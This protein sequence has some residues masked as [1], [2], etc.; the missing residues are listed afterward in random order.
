[1]K[2]L[3]LGGIFSLFYSHSALCTESLRVAAASDLRYA[4]TEIIDKFNSSRPQLRI[5]VTYGSSGKFYS[6][7]SNGAPFD[8]FFS[9]DE[10]YPRRLYEAGL[11]I[12]PPVRYATGRIVLWSRTRD[13]GKMKLSSL[14]ESSVGK[15]SIA[16]PA[17][18]PYGARAREALEKA[19]VWP[20][21]EKKLLLGENISQAAR[22][23]ESGGADFALL[24]MS[25]VAAPPLSQVGRYEIIS[26]DQH[27]PLRQSLLIMKSASDRGSAMSFAEF[28]VGKEGQKILS[29]F[30]FETP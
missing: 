10:E 5:E 13:P 22:F 16:N 20:V 15:I 29:K 12:S 23:A 21:V 30:G 19:G 27:K 7:L 4:M 6:Q 18:A 25:L 8:I 26:A 14:A 9:A 3:F 1:M 17:H 2:P 28:V 24:S 11:G